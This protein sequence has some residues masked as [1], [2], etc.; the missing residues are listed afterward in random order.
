M[1]ADDVMDA[2]SVCTSCRSTEGT[3]V[4]RSRINPTAAMHVWRGSLGT[5]FRTEAQ[6]VEVG[7][8]G[9]CSVC[10]ALPRNRMRI[11]KGGAA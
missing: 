5:H 8:D 10:R 11:V 7:A 6:R 3:Y 2:P 9:L 4:S 1:T